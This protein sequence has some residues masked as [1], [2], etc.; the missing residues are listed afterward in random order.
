[1]RPEYQSLA[2][3][4]FVS[5]ILAILV[6][7]AGLIAVCRIHLRAIHRLVLISSVAAAVGSL[8][9]LPWE[10]TESG[11]FPLTNHW[12]NVAAYQWFFRPPYG[13]IYPDAPEVAVNFGRVGLQ[14][15]IIGIMTLLGIML[16][17]RNYR[18][19]RS[20]SLHEART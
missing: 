17:Q 4:V 20:R 12:R 5:E 15:I 9:L 2:F 8:C 10:R 16:L 14:L 1:M 18:G 19:T 6:L 7:V 13:E 3:D 11:I